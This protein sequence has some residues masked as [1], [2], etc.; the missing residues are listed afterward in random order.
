M[1]RSSSSAARVPLPAH[2]LVQGAV[3][4]RAALGQGKAERG[5][6]GEA[7]SEIS[8]NPRAEGQ[9]D[10]RP[11]S[12]EEIRFREELKLDDDCLLFDG[13]GWPGAP[14]VWRT[15]GKGWHECLYC[16]EPFR[17]KGRS[18]R[19]R[20]CSAGCRLEALRVRREFREEMI[21]R[22]FPTGASDREMA[23]ATGL[24]VDVV[25]MKRFAMGMNEE[26]RESFA[27]EARAEDAD[28]D[29]S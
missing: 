24:A 22:L 11:R 7:M 21:A 17:R 10:G 14:S 8:G 25:R 4:Y 5:L 18:G 27:A 19:A 28:E 16:Y 3:V 2:G 13:N 29:F 23:N 1:R 9:P 15:H 20:F 12:P 6:G 26:T